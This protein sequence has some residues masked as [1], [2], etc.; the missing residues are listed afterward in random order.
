MNL[1]AMESQRVVHRLHMI[2]GK[3][4]PA[5]ASL[6]AIFST[7]INEEYIVSNLAHCQSKSIKVSIIVFMITPFVTVCLKLLNR[8]AAVLILHYLI[9]KIIVC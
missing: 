4:M 7:T 8:K 3:F 5:R 6:A 1:T 9:F 2:L